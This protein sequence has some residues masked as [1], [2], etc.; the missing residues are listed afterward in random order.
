MP[1]IDPILPRI[2]L[3]GLAVVGNIQD[4]V[5]WTTNMSISENFHA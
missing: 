2:Y 1:L 3:T 4:I 5:F